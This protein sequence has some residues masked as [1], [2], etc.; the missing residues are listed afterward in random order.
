MI[1]VWLIRHGESEANAGL[2]TQHP[3]KTPLTIKGQRQAQLV[4]AIMHHQPDWIIASPY[5][6]AQ[7]TALPL[8]D[9]FPITPYA[10][11]PVQEFTYLSVARYQDT[12]IE[13][14]RPLSDDYWQR[15]DPSYVDGEGAESFA[16]LLLR[17]E[18]A[19]AQL[20][21]LNADRVVI[22]SHGR[23]IRAM[24]WAALTGTTIVDARRMQQFQAFI[25]SFSVP[26]GSILKL[27]IHANDIWFSGIEIAHL[28]GFS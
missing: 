15:N 23:F 18:T 14:R 28:L 12:T 25:N 24:L 20:Y 7:Q 11:W 27:Q 9:R 19:Y 3:A 13:Q 8:R 4:A 22:F 21:K 10:E 1:N 5:R 16:D 26:N 17:V 2:P 6:R